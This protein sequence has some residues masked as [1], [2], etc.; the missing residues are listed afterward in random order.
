MGKSRKLLLIGSAHHETHVLRN[1]FHEIIALWKKVESAR[2]PLRERRGALSP[3]CT[4]CPAAAHCPASVAAAPQAAMP[5]KRGPNSHEALQ[6]EPLQGQQSR[7]LLV[8]HG[9][10]GVSLD[11]P[12]LEAVAIDWG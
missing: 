4:L 6:A 7:L 9:Q 12:A 10:S 3:P 8:V 11:G 2:S 1:A 5:C